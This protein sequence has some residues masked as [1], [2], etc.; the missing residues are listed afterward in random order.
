[1]YQTNE[2]YDPGSQSFNFTRTEKE[3]E[4]KNC[5]LRHA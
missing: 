2:K 5:T 1:M 4:S 3:P